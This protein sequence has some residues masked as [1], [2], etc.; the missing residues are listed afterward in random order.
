MDYEQYEKSVI[1]GVLL[2]LKPHGIKKVCL[3][4]IKNNY[5]N[6]ATVGPAID[7]AYWDTLYW[8]GKLE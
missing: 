4:T 5:N 7:D 3:D 8:E 1:A 2:K 6:G